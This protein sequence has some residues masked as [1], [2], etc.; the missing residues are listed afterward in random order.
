MLQWQV[1]FLLLVSLPAIAADGTVYIATQAE[2]WAISPNGGIKWQVSLDNPS[3]A[4]TPPVIGGDGPI[5]IGHNS[6][7]AINPDST[8]KWSTQLCGA[9]V[10][11]QQK[12][13]GRPD[14][15]PIET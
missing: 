9:A 6:L 5:Y 2:L 3:N 1:Y 11:H 14:E 12:S 15:R 13:I 10:P 4:N 8:L 7:Y